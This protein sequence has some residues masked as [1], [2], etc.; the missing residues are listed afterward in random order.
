[1]SMNALARSVGGVAA[2]VARRGVHGVRGLRATT[3]HVG[4]ARAASVMVGVDGSLCSED[5][6]HKALDTVVKP[7]DDLHILYVPPVLGTWG[8]GWTGG[9][10]KCAVCSVRC[11]V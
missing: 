11:G 6:L 8:G 2:V 7:G 5:A 9:V 1:M 4:G 3:G 10:R